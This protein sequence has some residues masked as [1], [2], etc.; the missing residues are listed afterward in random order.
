MF[1][2]PQIEEDLDAEISKLLHAM[3]EEEK[4]TEK[5]AAMVDQLSKLYELRHKSRISNE[6]LATIAANVAGIVLI[7]AHE[8]THVIA[9]K[10]FTLVK[11]LF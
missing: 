5:Y 3:S 6:T 11:K 10:A 2:K 4:T 7:L 8:R 1:K 9:T